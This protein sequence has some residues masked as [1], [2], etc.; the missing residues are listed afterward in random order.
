MFSHIW[1]EFV[2]FACKCFAIVS[3]NG[4]SGMATFKVEVQKQREDGT[5]AVKI[6]F[7]HNRKLK[8]LPTITKDDMT[9]SG[10]IKNQ[11]ISAKLFYTIHRERTD[12]A[13]FNKAINTGLKEVGKKIGLPGLQFYAARHSWATIARNDL[14]ISKDIINDAL[15]HID[16]NMAITDVYIKKDFSAIN[17]AN[18][19]VLDYVFNK[20]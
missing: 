20:E 9:H 14:E 2:T 12:I 10:K 7:T 11:R 17:K 1:Q 8:R 4:E 6:L 5:F 19:S 3:Q 15:N 16:K 18:K 13:T